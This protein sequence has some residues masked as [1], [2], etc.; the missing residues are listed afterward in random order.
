MARVRFDTFEKEFDSY[1]FKR[2]P[3]PT[4]VCESLCY[5]LRNLGVAIHNLGQQLAKIEGFDYDFDNAKVPSWIN[6]DKTIY[7]HPTKTM[8]IVEK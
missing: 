3:I 7:S 5:E 8:K 1:K 6:P 4:N 2:E